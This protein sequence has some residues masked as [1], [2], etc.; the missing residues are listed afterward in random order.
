MCKYIVAILIIVSVATMAYGAELNG[1]M[2]AQE[3]RPIKSI[4][5][6]TLMENSCTQCHVMSNGK[7]MLKETKPDAHLD[8]PSGTQIKN[9]GTTD[10]YGYME[11]GEIDYEMTERIKN[12]FDYLRKH[13]IKKSQ[14][15]ILS[16]GGHLLLGWRAK[17]FMDEW[18]LEG[19]IVETR[20]RALAASAAFLIFLAGSDGYRVANATAELMMHELKS[21]EGGFLFIKQSTPSSME[22][23]AKTLRHMQTTINDW[24]AKRGKMD[25]KKITECLQ[26]KELWMTGKQAKD[27]Y[28]F[29][30]VVIGE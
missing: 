13:N 9:F 18:K 12:H 7:W 22:E 1:K 28:G 16:G 5:P 20:V 23:E 6:K 24:I 8:P 25:K 10:A 2:V 15:E 17:A 27:E 30:D 3:T 21:I 4:C 19:G 29:V 14:M 11:V 26:F